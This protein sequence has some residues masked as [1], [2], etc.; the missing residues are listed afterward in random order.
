VSKNVK[1]NSW[2]A[3]LRRGRSWDRRALQWHSREVMV[4]VRSHTWLSV[5]ADVEGL[6]G[7]HPEPSF[8]RHTVWK[9]M[10]FSFR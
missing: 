7:L 2:R 10:R 1:E 9:P 6:G 8:F 5:N 3:E 4:G